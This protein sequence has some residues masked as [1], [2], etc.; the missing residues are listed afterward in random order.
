MATHHAV[1][2]ALPCRGRPRP[3]GMEHHLRLL[4]RGINP[5]TNAPFREG[6]YA[7]PGAGASACVA[8]WGAEAWGTGRGEVR[9]GRK[10]VGETDAGRRLAELRERV[11]AKAERNR[12]EEVKEA[13][14]GEERS[15]VERTGAERSGA[16]RSGTEKGTSGR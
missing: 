13:G 8:H 4:R 6:P 1:G 2:M 15:G 16:G 14:S 12:C 7:E 9:E 3:G 10:G 11:K 5:Q